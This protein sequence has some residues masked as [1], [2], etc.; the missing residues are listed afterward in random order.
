MTIRTVDPA[1]VAV[2]WPVSL[3]GFQLETALDPGGPWTLCPS[4]PF[5]YSSGQTVTI[6]VMDQQVFRL[7]QP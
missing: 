5:Y 4:P 7:M 3:N 2:T 1:D 6:P